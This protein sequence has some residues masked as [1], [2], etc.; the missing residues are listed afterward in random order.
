[1]ILLLLVAIACVFCLP[2]SV[3]CYCTH[4]MMKCSAAA[5]AAAAAAADKLL[6]L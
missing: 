6:Q 4:F 2:K 3:Y 1:M 5:A